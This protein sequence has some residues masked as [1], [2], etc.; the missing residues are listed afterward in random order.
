MALAADIGLIRGGS[1]QHA[2][3]LIVRRAT[4]YRRWTSTMNM[5]LRTESDIALAERLFNELRLRTGTPQ[6]ITRVSYG[7]GEQVAHDIVE[8]EARKIGLE[9]A[10]DAARNLYMTCRGTT[11]G[12]QIFIGSHLDSVP[13]GGNYDGSAGVLMGLSVLSGFLQA[14]ITPPRD[15]TIMA[16]RAEESTWFGASDIG[17]RAALGLLEGKTARGASVSRPDGAWSSDHRCER[18]CQRFGPR[19]CVPDSSER[20]GLFL[21]PHIEQGPVLVE[22]STPVGIVTGICGSFRYRHARCEGSYSHSGATPRAYRA[23]AVRATAALVT[24]LDGAWLQL[25]AD[26]HVLT[27]TFCQFEPIPT[28]QPFQKLPVRVHSHSTSAAKSPETLLLMHE[29][30]GRAVDLIEAAHK[31]RFRAGGKTVSGS[32]QMDRRVVDSLR[33]SAAEVGVLAR[34]MPSGAGH[35]LAVFA[36][37]GVPTRN[38]LHPKPE[39]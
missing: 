12:K 33:R 4:K 15:I 17:S 28:R 31:V 38:D 20:V 22:E 5:N 30:L 7:S 26:G 21:E 14:G 10:T 2:V 36:R 3:G 16:I 23:D 39:R 34:V 18:K 6:G 19:T 1:G 32:A 24:A 9:I 8:R 29:E 37:C 27:V 25:E 35:D 13:C 11:S